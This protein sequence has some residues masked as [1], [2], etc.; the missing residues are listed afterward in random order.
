M[1]IERISIDSRVLGGNVLAIQDFD[2]AADFAAFERGYIA[3]YAPVYVSAK[4]PLERISQVHALESA[5]FQLAECQI[6]STIKLRKSYDVSTFPYDF[7]RVVREE[8]LGGVLD[9]A[10]T[11]FVHDRFT[12]DRAIDPAASGARYRGY[13]RQ[14][15]VSPDEAVYRLIDREGR[16]L[17]F[18]THRYVSGT[19]VLFL[20]GGVHADYKNLGLGLINEYF[21]FNELIRKG[22]RKGITHIS[23]ANYPVFN[24]EIAQLGFRVLTTFAVMRKTYSRGLGGNG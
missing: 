2:P 12:A 16:T 13:V 15:F 20:L 8:D 21:E 3:D 11:T 14:S 19:E 10:A 4:I 18:K 1:K 17:A 24:L 9:I 22:I 6:R 5:G 23:A 7:E